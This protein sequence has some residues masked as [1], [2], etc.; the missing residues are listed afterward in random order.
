MYSITVVSLLISVAD[1]QVTPSRWQQ[2]PQSALSSVPH[3]LGN[4]LHV[5]KPRVPAPAQVRFRTISNVFRSNS[6][7]VFADKP[8]GFGQSSK[9]RQ[10]KAKA[11]PAPTEPPPEGKVP[12]YNIEADTGKCGEAFID[13]NSA[14]VFGAVTGLK[15]G[16]CSEQGYTEPD[17]SSEI[18]VPFGDAIKLSYF[19]KPGSQ[20]LI[21]SFTNVVRV[22]AMMLIGLLAG[23]IS[24]CAMLRFKRGALTLNEELL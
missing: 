5:V 9:S 18:K 15:K 22:P 14:S 8:L 12:M 16:T 10:K 2:V 17:G 1:G 3:A 6:Q 19:K 24:T 4:Q 20:V 23:S 11:T 7:L 13:K 21:Q